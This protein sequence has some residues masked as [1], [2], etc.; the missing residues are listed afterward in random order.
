MGS[1]DGL[2]DP[3]PVLQS[4]SSN[5]NGNPVTET[6]WP[7][8]IFHSLVMSIP[9]LLPAPETAEVAPLSILASL[10]SSINCKFTVTQTVLQPRCRAPAYGPRA[11]SSESR[12]LFVCAASPNGG[13]KLWLDGEVSHLV[14]GS[15]VRLMAGTGVAWCVLNEGDEELIFLECAEVTSVSCLLLTFATVPIDADFLNTLGC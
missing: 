3:A 8:T 15:C 1:H 13:A 12:L 14:T 4:M 10:T 6:Y 11:H 5:R 7:S 2:P 9:N